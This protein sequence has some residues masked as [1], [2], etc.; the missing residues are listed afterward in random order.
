MIYAIE[1]GWNGPAKIGRAYDP[2][3]RLSAMQTGNP[4]PLYVVGAFEITRAD[5]FVQW[6]ENEIEA[7]SQAI[8]VD[9]R[10]HGEW[11]AP[12]SET[13]LLISLMRSPEPSLHIAAIGAQLAGMPSQSVLQ[14]RENADAVFNWALGKLRDNPGSQSPL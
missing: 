8:I 7:I 6:D 2:W 13:L 10:L 11:F 1:S 4:K 12:N 5:E 9:S 3:E 14:N